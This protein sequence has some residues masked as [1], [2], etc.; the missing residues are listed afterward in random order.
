[1]KQFCASVVMLRI[2]YN[3]RTLCVLADVLAAR[4]LSPVCLAST[5]GLHNCDASANW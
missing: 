2:L 4:R 5:L 3:N 1:M